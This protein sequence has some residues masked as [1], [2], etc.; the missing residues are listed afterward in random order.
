MSNSV[1]GEAKIIG[2]IFACLVKALSNNKLMLKNL[3]YS[4]EAVVD[5]CICQ[6]EKTLRDMESTNILGRILSI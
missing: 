4:N 6:V 2:T 1:A 5:Y 3:D